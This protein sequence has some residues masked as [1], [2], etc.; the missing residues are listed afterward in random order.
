MGIAILCISFLTPLV[1][2]LVNGT[3]YT[4]AFSISGIGVLLYFINV[5]LIRWFILRRDPLNP[6][7]GA[8]GLLL[9]SDEAKRKATGKRT[10][11]K[12]VSEIGL[13]GMA[14]VPSGLVVALLLALDLV[15]YR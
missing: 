11:P 15:S 14:F 6:L 3:T 2:A 12:W 9:L 10:V 8:P 4:F 13:I 5:F 1:V 7:R